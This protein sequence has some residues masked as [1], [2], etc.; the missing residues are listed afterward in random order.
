MKGLSW[1]LAF[2]VILFI[3]SFIY[4]FPW[5]AYGINMPLTGGDYKLGLDLNG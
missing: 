1:R 5:N 3:A 4:V 2:V